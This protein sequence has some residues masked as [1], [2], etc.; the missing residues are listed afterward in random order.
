M[1]QMWEIVKTSYTNKHDDPLLLL[2]EKLIELNETG[3]RSS[4][5]LLSRRDREIETSVTNSTFDFTYRLVRDAMATYMV[6]LG[7]NTS[8]SPKRNR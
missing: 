8:S 1:N 2:L 4:F 6:P 5:G 7:G 3:S